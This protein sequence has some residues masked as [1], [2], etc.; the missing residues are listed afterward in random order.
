MF[1]LL[2]KKI[3][4]VTTV[5]EEEFDYFKSIIRFETITE[6]A[7]FFAGRRCL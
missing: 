7:I 4:A 3:S 5:N 2:Y 6:K 1:E